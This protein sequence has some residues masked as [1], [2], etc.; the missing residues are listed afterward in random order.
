MEYGI[1]TLKMYHEFSFFFF[2]FFFFFFLFYMLK[3]KTNKKFF[4]DEVLI[5]I[6]IYTKKNYYLL[7]TYFNRLLL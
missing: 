3:I 6:Q 5:M 4:I 2:F 1:K 7:Y